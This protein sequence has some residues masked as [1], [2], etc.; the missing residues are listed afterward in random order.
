MNGADFPSML[1]ARQGSRLLLSFSI[2]R[3]GWCSQ[4]GDPAEDPTVT[5]HA[6]MNA[7]GSL[8]GALALLQG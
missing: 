2:C 3:W 7:G 6:Q 5:C 8:P 4:G 1:L